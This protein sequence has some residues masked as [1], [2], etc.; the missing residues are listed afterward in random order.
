MKNESEIYEIAEQARA[1]Q[2]ERRRASSKTGGG[3]VAGSM[4]QLQE[5]CVVPRAG[6]PGGGT[7]RCER[8]RLVRDQLGKDLEGQAKKLCF[9]QLDHVS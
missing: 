2:A 4:R 1:F 3:G 9:R 6:P 7:V 8:G 5:W